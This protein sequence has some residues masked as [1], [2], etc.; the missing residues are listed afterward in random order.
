MQRLKVT[1][2]EG[3][4]TKKKER[5]DAKKLS[6]LRSSVIKCV[7]GAAYAYAAR[8]HIKYMPIWT[9]RSMIKIGLTIFKTHYQTY[10][11][12]PQT[13]HLSPQTKSTQNP[14]SQ[15]RTRVR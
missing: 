14:L 10:Y 11:L 12:N 13:H 9:M 1:K 3:G 5:R 6:R 7:Y 8:Y 15:F 2:L 4:L